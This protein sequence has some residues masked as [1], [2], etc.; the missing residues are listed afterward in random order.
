M[1]EPVRRFDAAEFL[2]TGEDFD[3]LVQDAV[4][5]GD[6]KVMIAALSTIARARGMTALAEK[7]GISREGLY[8]A[9]SEAGNPSFANVVSIVRAMGLRVTFQPA[10]ATK[11]TRAPAKKTARA[12]KKAPRAGKRRS[13]TVAHT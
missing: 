7:A 1:K 9:L 13:E 2:S 10:V 11:K 4:E 3:V 8:K 6:P 12:V 5:S